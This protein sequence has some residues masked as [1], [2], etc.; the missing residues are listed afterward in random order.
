[1]KGLKFKHYYEN[2]WK[3]RKKKEPKPIEPIRSVIP[4]SLV[5]YSSYGAVLYQ[6]PKRSK[7]LDIGCG[8]GNVS[9]LFLMKNCEV[10]GIEVSGTALKHAHEKRLDTIKSDANFTLPLVKKY[11]EVVVLI[12]TLE[13]VIDPLSLLRECYRTLKENGKVIVSVPNFARLSNRIRMLFGDPIDLLHSS[14]YGDDL[15]HF[16]WFT[17]PKLR[18]FL[19]R[20]NF[21]N[22]TISPVG[23]PFGFL[24]GLMGLQLSRQIIMAGIKT[25]QDS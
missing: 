24:F 21:R 14:K 20:A 1:M 16:H 4:N 23:L 19:L 25:S 3:R 10:I 7:V 6:I 13:H 18:N 5:K 22:I 2:Y 9:S 11:F 12:D 17:V 8:D 15:E